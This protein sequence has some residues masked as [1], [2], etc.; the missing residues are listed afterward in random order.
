MWEVCD[1]GLLEGIS[2]Q[3]DGSRWV[4]LKRK[5]EHNILDLKIT[6]LLEDDSGPNQVTKV[7]IIS[8]FGKGVYLFTSK[9][10][11]A[12]IQAKYRHSMKLLDSCSL[13]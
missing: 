2:V 7:C 5:K 13:S 11:I 10:F 3:C 1:C 12:S 4:C 6:I 8:L 9:C